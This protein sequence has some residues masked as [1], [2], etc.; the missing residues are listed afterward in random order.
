M[1]ILSLSAAAVSACLFTEVT[2]YCLHILLHSERISWLSR[3]HMI[4]HLKVYGPRR[5]LRQPGP[6]KDS[7]AG[8]TALAGVG[9]EWILP[10]GLIL[11]GAL[12]AFRALHVPALH[13]AVFSVTALAWGKFMFGTMHDSM[14]VEGWWMAEAPVI[15]GW[16][17]KIRRLH[18]I[19]HLEFSD[20]GKLN[21]NFGICVYLLDRLL[22]SHADKAHP[23]SEQGY[24]AALRRYAAVIG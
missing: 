23:F 17:R 7:T 13:Q 6:Y 15:G 4:H 24:Q 21:Y 1:T 14:H 20:D 3:D 9:L 18:D 16:Y 2:G 22:G 10:I 11:L 5:S 8:R 12:A 19:H